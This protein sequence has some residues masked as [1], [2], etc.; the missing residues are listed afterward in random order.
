[1]GKEEPKLYYVIKLYSEVE[2]YNF[3][4][5]SHTINLENELVVIYEEKSGKLVFVTPVG[6]IKCITTMY[7]FGC[8]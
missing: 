7:K 1:M 6:E 5:D 8:F 4:Y 3:E 2:T